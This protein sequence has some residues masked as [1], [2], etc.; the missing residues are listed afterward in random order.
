M[1]ECVSVC[2]GDEDCSFEE[3]EKEERDD[4]ESRVDEYNTLASCERAVVGVI[5]VIAVVLI[6]VV[7]PTVVMFRDDHDS[8]SP[9]HDDTDQNNECENK[10]DDSREFDAPNEWHLHRLGL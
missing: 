4:S 8:D 10:A 9:T 2:S 1:R 3:N 7:L 5:A 6:T